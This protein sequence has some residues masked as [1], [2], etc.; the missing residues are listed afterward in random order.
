MTTGDKRVFVDTNILIY[1]Q[2]TEVPQHKQ[3]LSMLNA[4][5]AGGHKLCLSRQ[6]FR[7]YIAALSRP[8][9]LSQPLGMDDLAKD[10]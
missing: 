1:S 2:L 9:L 7:E 10:V 4:L 3:P 8:G 6:V 5:L